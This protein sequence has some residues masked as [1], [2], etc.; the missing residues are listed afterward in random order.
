MCSEVT[1]KLVSCEYLGA[2]KKRIT[3]AAIR[4]LGTTA[5]RQGRAR[6]GEIG[7][8][9]LLRVTTP[10]KWGVPVAHVADV[11][12]EAELAVE[13]ASEVRTS[14]IRVASSGSRTRRGSEL[15]GGL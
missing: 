1:A 2:R 15:A 9:S 10:L 12:R 8:R 4:G 11:V 13:Y 6:V 3:I 7:S 14:F 5:L